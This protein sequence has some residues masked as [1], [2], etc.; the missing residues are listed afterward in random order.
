MT[1]K[2][3]TNPISNTFNTLNKIIKGIEENNTPDE[4]LVTHL[5]SIREILSQ[6]KD[7]PDKLKQIPIGFQKVLN[8]LEKTCNPQ[9][10]VYSAWSSGDNNKNKKKLQLKNE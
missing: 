9:K 5:K 8:E 1:T 6:L 4:N 10:M 2:T 7:V 3:N